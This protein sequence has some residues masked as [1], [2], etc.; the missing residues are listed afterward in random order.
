MKNI[1]PFL[2]L[3]LITIT[4][5]YS[6]NIE[7]RLYRD[8]WYVN[9]SGISAPALKTE[10]GANLLNQNNLS[11]EVVIQE[12]GFASISEESTIVV[13]E[14]RNFFHEK[15]Y[16]EETAE[17]FFK[18]DDLSVSL[19]I[20]DTPKLWLDEIWRILLVMASFFIIIIGIVVLRTSGLNAGLI[21]FGLAL[22]CIF[23]A[24]APD[25]ISDP[26]V[27]FIVSFFRN[28]WNILVNWR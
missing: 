2:L 23:I 26:I 4:M 19:D 27:F 17:G 14:K 9:R 6:C 25:W 21:V 16:A 18:R 7:K 5:L 10:I 8:G 24:L 22:F 28:I 3:L 1:H 13:A 11:A 15:D 12:D 20:E